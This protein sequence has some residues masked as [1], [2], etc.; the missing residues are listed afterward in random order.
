[1]RQK[2]ITLCPTTWESAA[3]MRN[4]SKWIREQL[5][6]RE[7]GFEIRELIEE[8]DH[9]SNLI[10]AI[11]MGEKEWKQGVGWVDTDE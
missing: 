1:M 11:A 6:Y 8:I 3:K 9:L 10:S 5:R 7:Q 2:M 4:F